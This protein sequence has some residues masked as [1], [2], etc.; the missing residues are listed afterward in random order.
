MRHRVRP[1]LCLPL[2]KF[3]MMIRIRVTWTTPAT[4]GIEEYSGAA[5]IEGKALW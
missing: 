1:F 4:P 2:R 5:T 3:I